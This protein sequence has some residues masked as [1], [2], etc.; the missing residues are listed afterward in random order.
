MNV[1]AALSDPTRR[2]ILSLLAGHGELR[3]GE[4]AAHFAISS[5]AISQHLKVLRDAGLL[6]VKKQA[7]Q[8]LYRLDRQ[9]LN[10][11]GDW[12]AALQQPRQPQAE[13]PDAGP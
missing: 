12:L 5:A 9:G 1:F 13:S 8:R 10:A 4:I 6:R 11:A 7:Q 3:A 2:A